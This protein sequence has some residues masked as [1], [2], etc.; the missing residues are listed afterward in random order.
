MSLQQFE[1]VEAQAPDRPVRLP[2][3]DALPRRVLHMAALRG[4]GY[5]LRAIGRNYGVSPQAVSVMLTRHKKLLRAARSGTGMESLSARA[6]NVLGRLRIGSRSE[7]RAVQDWETR[8]H[9]LRNCGRKTIAEIRAWA[10]DGFTLVELLVVI[11]ILAVLAAFA[12][13][14]LSSAR[15]K[16]QTAEATSQ[17][18]AI[19]AANQMHAAENNG[20]IA[21]EGNSPSKFPLSPGGSGSYGRL[22]PYM[23]GQGRFAKD[24]LELISFWTP[25]R[26]PAVPK[27]LSKDNN[28]PM[29]WAWNEFFNMDWGPGRRMFQFNQP[30]KVLYVVTGR[31]EIVPPMATNPA[32]GKVPS[33]RRDGFYF[34][35]NGKCPAVFL[36]GHVELLSFPVDPKIIRPF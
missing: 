1:T 24:W 21:G 29:T 26:D 23:S 16:A 13:P 25:R 28:W 9:G 36:D 18:R 7:A 30:G 20:L 8:L 12:V 32:Q 2:D 4:L 10:A 35:H 5:P 11:A 19:G 31:G 22:Y 34:V 33:S 15:A 3:P 6:V 17:L 27:N 14:A